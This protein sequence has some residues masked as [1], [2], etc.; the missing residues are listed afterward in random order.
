M[1][2]ESIAWVR[3]YFK[4]HAMTLYS[5][6]VMASISLYYNDLLEPLADVSY[7]VSANLASTLSRG[8]H[9]TT[10]SDTVTLGISPER[11]TALYDTI[12]PLPR[13]QLLEDLEA[14]YAVN[15][16][17]LAIDL[18]V[19]PTPLALSQ[20]DGGA[21]A[22]CEAR[23]TALLSLHARKTILITPF[24]ADNA[25]LQ[26]AK[27]QW[28]GE[29]C[30]SGV[31]FAEPFLREGISSFVYA[32]DV[33]ELSMAHAL[34]A[35]SKPTH[36]VCGELFGASQDAV[37]QANGYLTGDWSAPFS[38]R[39]PD[40][41][42]QV[43]PINFREF[44]SR[45]QRIDWGITPPD[46]EG[47]RD[48]TVIFGARYG[49][50]DLFETP[51]G[52]KYGMDLH[53]A[54]KTTLDHPIRASSAWEGWASDVVLGLVIGVLVAF[55]WRNYF[56][57][58]D[59]G[60]VFSYLWLMGAIFIFLA[61]FIALSLIAYASLVHLGVWMSP[62]PMAAGMFLDFFVVG[63]VQTAMT[64]WRQGEPEATFTSTAKSD[65]ATPTWRPGRW[66]NRQLLDPDRTIRY[67]L[68]WVIR[69]PLSLFIPLAFYSM[70]TP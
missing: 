24:P 58:V 19:S 3:R 20:R 61:V 46:L 68:G 11:H 38:T 48:Q 4:R 55:V 29:L 10:R 16:T 30:R 66:L 8:E 36:S 6:F 35:D 53:A 42:P 50:D 23:I 51:L 7:V 43:L 69:N 14:I 62:I 39:A 26:Q 40:Q 57:A 60:W 2:Q 70:M 21:S 32:Y 22:A 25:T 65:A 9:K 27:H 13:C 12:S 41:R 67:R 33:S 54:I 52:R 56:A 37:P 44:E 18:D 45:V 17:R 15:P 28:M 1:P 63:T 31:T 5:A 64:Q 34:R 47:L 59:A 49:Q